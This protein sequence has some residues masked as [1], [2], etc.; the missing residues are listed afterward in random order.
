MSIEEVIRELMA[1]GLDSIPG[2]AARSSCRV[3]RS[4]RPQK[5]GADR[6]LRGDGD[7]HR[8]G[9][10]PTVTMM[11]GSAKHGDRIEISSGARVQ[12]QN[13]RVHCVHLR[14]LAPENRARAPAKTDA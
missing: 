7:P 3:T 4:S 5:A 9:L 14:P 13:A 2:A 10:R 6:W 1:A 12:T 11:Y 8:L